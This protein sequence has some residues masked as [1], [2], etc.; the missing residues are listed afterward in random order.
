M[1]I[2]LLRRA[3][4]LGPLLVLA[5]CG[6]SWPPAIPVPMDVDGGRGSE[7]GNVTAVPAADDYIDADGDHCPVF[8]TDRPF[9]TTAVLRIRTASC[10]LKDVPGKLVAIELDRRVVPIVASAPEPPDSEAPAPAQ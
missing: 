10:P 8:T 7:F 5:A 3:L 2:A 4:S 9:T 6:P 1:T